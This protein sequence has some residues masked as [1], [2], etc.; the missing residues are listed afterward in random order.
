MKNIIKTLGYLS[1]IPLILACKQENLPTYMDVDRVHFQWAKSSLS[2]NWTQVN[3]GYDNPIKNDSTIAIPVAMIGKTADTDRP[4]TAEVIRAESTASPGNDIE[5]LH[6]V[7]PAGKH[8]GTLL[9]KVK[10]SEKIDTVTLSARLRL[11]PNAHF[12]VDYIKAEGYGDRNGIEY[13]IFFDAKNDMPNLW[14]DP[15]AGARLVDFFGAYSKVK[16]ELLCEVF[17]ITRD[18]FMY[19]PDGGKTALQVLG[20]KFGDAIIIGMIAQVNRYLKAYEQEHGEPLKDENG[21]V[22]RMGLQ[23][24]R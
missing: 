20:E 4:L 9:I 18:F 13:N 22:I 14:A 19:D 5:V 7:I 2:D 17:G 12:H 21:N 10:Y 11:T 8:E 6:S 16:L 1:L 15:E 3:L 24:D 23:I